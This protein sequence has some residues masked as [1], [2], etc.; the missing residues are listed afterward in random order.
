MLEEI[1]VMVVD[2]QDIGSRSYTF[3]AAMRETLEACFQAGKPV[4]ILDRPNPLGG[5]KVDGP[6]VDPEWRSYVSA[7]PVPYVHGLTM[8]ELARFAL[9]APGVLTLDEEQRQ[10]AQLMIVPMRGWRRD[11]RWP[12]TGLRWFPT[13]PYVQNFSAVEGYPITGLGCMIGGFTHGVG[14]DDPFRGLAYPGMRADELIAK[15]TA[16]NIRGLTFQKVEPV[17]A[18]GKK[19]EGVFVEISDWDS[20]RLAELN[21]HLMRL[22]CLWTNK[23]PF[24][25]ATA[26]EKQSF[27]RHVGST[28]WWKAITTQGGRVPVTAFVDKWETRA[29]AF[30]ERSRAIW[31]YPH[32]KPPG[33]VVPIEEAPPASAEER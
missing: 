20:V 1:D 17:D 13:S 19:L 18:N 3:A 4:I 24:V 16:Q 9:A 8:G 23:N 25:A 15:L 26:D 10:Q 22:A 30:Q 14:R 33:A 27:N 12:D 5:L 29:L 32:E 11:M 6:M 7:F 21:F 2:L 28:E 31:L